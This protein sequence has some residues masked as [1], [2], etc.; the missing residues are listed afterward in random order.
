MTAGPGAETAPAPGPELVGKSAAAC[1]SEGADRTVARF[2]ERSPTGGLGETAEP[3]ASQQNRFKKK[4]KKPFKKDRNQFLSDLPEV[5]VDI[6]YRVNLVVLGVAAEQVIQSACS[7]QAS[8]ELGGGVAKE[9]SVG[10]W[11]EDNEEGVLAFVLREGGGASA[12]KARE[13]NRCL[14]QVSSKP[15]RL[16]KLAF[17]RVAPEADLPICQTPFEALSTIM[18]ITLVVSGSMLGEE[19]NARVNDQ[20]EALAGFVESLRVRTPTKLR[21]VR[22]VLLCS[23]EED[24]R[25]GPASPTGEWTDLLERYE[26][27]HGKLVKFGPVCASDKEGVHAAVTQIAAA[28]VGPNLTQREARQDSSPLRQDDAAQLGAADRMMEESE[29]EC[30]DIAEETTETEYSGDSSATPADSDGRLKASCNSE[31]SMSEA[32]LSMEQ[33]FNSGQQRKSNVAQEGGLELMGVM[34][35]AASREKRELATPST[36][37]TSAPAPDAVIVLPGSDG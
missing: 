36:A 18:V 30:H 6:P 9:M 21:P 8:T 10:L 19:P 1:S 29:Q 35:Q 13:A 25:L 11:E 5:D 37:A 16:A 7:S 23:M 3:L 33:I 34:P 31:T 24:G 12:D 2:P 20:L 17:S 4:K 32:L 28:R 15:Q 26:E 14:C 22:V 27:D